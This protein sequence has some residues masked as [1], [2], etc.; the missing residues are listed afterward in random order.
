[1]V[2]RVLHCIIE[3]FPFSYREL[4][5]KPTILS[6]ADWH[7]LL[8]RFDKRFAAWKGHSLS[9]GGRLIL[10]NSVLSSLPLYFMSFYFPQ[11]VIE[12][13]D[14][15]RCAFFW[16]GENNTNEGQCL[17]SWDVLCSPC[18]FD[19]WEVLTSP[20]CSNGGENCYQITNPLGESGH[21]QL[22]VATQIFGPSGSFREECPYSSLRFLK[23]QMHSKFD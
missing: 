6:K 7:L 10:V 17:V 8:D 15:L 19:V 11:W 2:S 12:H 20:S 14:K 13:I 18:A 16:N 1:M 5:L 22:L 3:S 4:P 9:H 21:T 23:L